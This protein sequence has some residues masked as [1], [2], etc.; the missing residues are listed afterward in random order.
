M[1][2]KTA[3]SYVVV[4]AIASA[5][6]VAITNLKAPAQAQTPAGQTSTELFKQVM[7]DVMGRQFTVRLTERDPGNGSAAV[8]EE[9][10]A[11]GIQVLNKPIKP[12]AL[13]ASLAQC[14]IH[15]VA[16]AE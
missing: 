10:R 1:Q 13:R 3:L 6:T 4:A 5:A 8:R 12:A 16:A 14:R 7:T 2:I 11:H 9:A 15:R